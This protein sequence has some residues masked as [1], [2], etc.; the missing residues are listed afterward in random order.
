[1][2]DEYFYFK[3]LYLYICAESKNNYNNVFWKNISNDDINWIIFEGLFFGDELKHFLNK[4]KN[5]NH[6]QIE[7]LM[8]FIERGP[9]LNNNE[10]DI[11]LQWKQRLYAALIHIPEF[12]QK[13]AYYLNKTKIDYV[14][15]PAVLYNSSL[16]NEDGNTAIS[17]LS[18]NELLIKSSSE[19]VKISKSLDKD[20]TPENNIYINGLLQSFRR[21]IIQYPEKYF[22]DLMPFL[23]APISMIST[24][25]LSF[26]DLNRSNKDFNIGMF[27]EFVKSYL[28]LHKWE[29]EL[30]NYSPREYITPSFIFYEIYSS[31]REL[32][33]NNSIKL[34]INSLNEIRNILLNIIQFRKYLKDEV[35]NLEDEDYLNI[36]INSPIGNIIEAY[37]FC[38]RKLS[39][40]LDKND[41][42]K[43][44]V[45]DRILFNCLLKE[46][47]IQI[48]SLLGFH[49]NLFFWFD[50]KWSIDFLKKSNKLLAKDKKVLWKAF[51][52]GYMWNGRVFIDLYELMHDNYVSLFDKPINDNGHSIKKFTHSFISRIFK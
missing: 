23:D 40:H 42:V 35:L 15:T 48:Y 13:H 25:F 3:K 9:Q 24:I 32:M 17:P 34:N 1:M 10:D 44:K 7:K 6:N 45:E 29:N 5:L 51:V 12:K 27:N 31:Y 21:F 33:R 30:I 37:I 28:D 52:N 47:V 20:K 49:I 41:Q 2:D 36:T 26:Q 39:E 18:D 4:L 16:F 43:W 8:G 50:K 11:S 46:E 38:L 14:L 22:E 19:I